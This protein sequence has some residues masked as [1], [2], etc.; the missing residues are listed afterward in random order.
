MARGIDA[1]VFISS[2]QKAESVAD[3]AKDL[4]MSRGGAYFTAQKLKK[5][6][7]PLKK[8]K[9]NS[10]ERYGTGELIAYAKSLLKSGQ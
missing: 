8:F 4:G 3:V 2:W 1:K 5:L 9:Y 7:V 10:G 6:G